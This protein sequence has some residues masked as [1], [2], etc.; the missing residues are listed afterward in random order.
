MCG[1]AGIFDHSQSQIPKKAMERLL[2]SMVQSIKHRGPDDEGVYCEGGVGLGSSRL[3]IIDLSPLGHMPMK[4]EDTGN[5]IVYNGEVYNYK[6]L[7]GLLGLRGL[8]SQTDTEIVLKAYAKYGVECLKYFNGIYAFCI[9]DAKKRQ[10]FCVR[11]RLGVK[12]FFYTFHKN[13]FYFSSEIKGLL[14]CGVP[15]Q[16]NMQTI[17]DYLVYG[18]Y[19]HSEQTFFQGIKQ[20]PPGCYL[21]VE[22][23]RV[24][25]TRYWDICASL[26]NSAQLV[27][28]DLQEYVVAG[29]RFLE[30]L[31]DSLRLQLRSDVPIAVH[32]SGGLDSA[33]MMAALNKLQ[34]GQGSLKAFSYYY[35][36]PKY[37]ERPFV[38]E[39]VKK[40]GW[41]VEY[42]QLSPAEVPALAQEAIWYQEQPFPGVITLAKHKLIKG[43]HLFGAKVI[44]EGQGGDEIGAGYQYVF[45]AHI[46]DLLQNGQSEIALQEINAFG[47]QNGLSAEQSFTK[48]INGL[49][50]YYC[51]GRSA[52]GTQF[53]KPHCLNPD[54]LQIYHHQ[55]EDFPRPF[56]SNLLNMQYRDIL[57]TK[58]PRIL[59]SCDRASMAYG[60]ELRVPF[61]DHRLVEFAFSLPGRV[62]IQN[63][64]QRFFIREAFKSFFPSQLAD[65]PKRAVV[66]PQRKWL[67]TSLR[68]WA[69]EILSANSLKELGIFNQQQILKE[70]AEYKK[71]PEDANLNSFH[72]WQWISL[73]LWYQTFFYHDASNRQ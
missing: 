20:L 17:Y 55:L 65:L 11:D 32:V 34:G 45:G 28:G 43:S 71:Y 31:K 24:V 63:G 4:D 19:D 38:E 49:A 27:S 22:G 2:K 37:D 42:H 3:S 68:E 66:D 7:K 47:R 21:T 36:E 35:G 41:D 59:R 18:V 30:I 51:G 60:R 52:D 54:F 1:I 67:Q 16:P 14:S 12:P 5:W 26:E 40:M 44:L 23:D 50:A 48:V 33:L 13:V 62:K 70:Y 53:V 8:K 6:E 29:E 10:L 39:L 57:H 61:L 58:L 25:V 15:C 72:V 69:Q 64:V 73:G 56:K 46:L 9:W